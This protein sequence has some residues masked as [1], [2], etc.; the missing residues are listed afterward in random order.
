MLPKTFLIL[1]D[2]NGKSDDW[3]CSNTDCNYTVTQATAYKQMETIGMELSRMKK[4]S[5]EVCK[6][7]I[8]KHSLITLHPNH[9]YLTDVNFALIQLLGG[10]G[11]Q[12]KNNKGGDGL[13]KA[14]DEDLMLKIKICRS[15]ESLVKIIAPGKSLQTAI[16]LYLTLSFI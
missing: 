11:Q 12:Q 3:Y 5:L 6:Q 9:Y 1:D 14:L 8:D 4:G 15:L 10:S 16:K 2:N 7:F 13:I